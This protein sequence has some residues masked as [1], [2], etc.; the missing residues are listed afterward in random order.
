MYHIVVVTCV[1]A[2]VFLCLYARPFALCVCVCVCVC[3]CVCVC[4][5]VCLRLCVFPLILFEPSVC[6]VNQLI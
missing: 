1:S 5:C 2:Y 3:A 6:E 4:V